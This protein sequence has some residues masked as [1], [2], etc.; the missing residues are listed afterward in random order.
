MMNVCQIKHSLNNCIFLKQMKLSRNI[1]QKFSISDFEIYQM[2]CMCK[3]KL[4]YVM[5][6]DVLEVFCIPFYPLYI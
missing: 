6:V 1:G 2:T 5:D 3:F 4:D